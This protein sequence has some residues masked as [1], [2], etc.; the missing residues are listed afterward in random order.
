MKKILVIALFAIASSLVAQ[1][2]AEP[3]HEEHAA[4]APGEA[5]EHEAEEPSI[6]WKWINFAILTG[7]LSVIIAK[8]VPKALAARTA[9]IQKDINEAQ[10]I[11]RD[12]EARA[13][14]MDARLKA[15]GAEI[16]TFRQRST[17]EMQQEGERIRQET[18]AQI[19][20]VEQQAALEIENAGKIAARE[21]RRYSAE[22][23]LKLAEE[24]VRARLDASSEAALVDGFLK[25]L[26]ERGAN[27]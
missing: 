10:Q 12:A 19:K 18:A 13:A 20:K 26:E 25:E 8:T 16:E 17:A 24:R 1:E 15:L 5:G 14:Q 11:K 22:L 4:E 21:L 6:I 7:G 3:A 27:N 23:A 2:S 9:N